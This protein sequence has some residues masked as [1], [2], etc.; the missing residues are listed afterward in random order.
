LSPLQDIE[1]GWRDLIETRLNKTAGQRAAY[2]DFSKAPEAAAW[3]A[4]RRGLEPE[5]QW[6][7]WVTKG[8]GRGMHSFE[9]RD[10]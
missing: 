9:N 5:A 6:E 8:R 7:Q 2:G 4:S 3:I 10:E 1:A